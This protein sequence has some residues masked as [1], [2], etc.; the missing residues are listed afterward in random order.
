M[1]KTRITANEIEPYVDAKTV[2]SYFGLSEQ[3][4][5]LLSAPRCPSSERIPHQYFGRRKRFKITEV[6]EYFNERKKMKA[7]K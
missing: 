2:A 4:I 3:Y 6:E 5:Q 7:G 1:L